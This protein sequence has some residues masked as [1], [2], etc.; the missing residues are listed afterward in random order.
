MKNIEGS[1]VHLDFDN[2]EGSRVINKC[3]DG[4][5]ANL[6]GG[7]LT[8]QGK[9][10]NAIIFDGI[11]DYIH[12]NKGEL[13]SP[14][15][16]SVWVKRIFVDSPSATIVSSNSG[17]IL[18]EQKNSDSKLGIIVDNKSYTFN[19]ATPLGYWTHLI[20]IG[21]QSGVTL[22]V[23]GEY[24]DVIKVD[25]PC[26][27]DYL[28]CN[29]DLT[30]FLRATLDEFMVFNKA[31]NDDEIQ[32]LC[33]PTTTNFK[34]EYPCPVSSDGDP[35][36]LMPIPNKRQLD[37]QKLEYIAFAHFGM[38]T[39]SDREWGDGKE[40]PKDFYPSELSGSQWARVIKN[41]GIKQLILTAKHHDGFCL[42]PSEYTDHCVKNSLW[43][44]GKG[45]VVKEISDA[46]HKENIKFGVYLS[47]WDRHEPTF[48]SGE[49]Y[50]T[51][52]K[53]Q[54]TEL[55]TNYGEISEIWFDGANGS[56][57]KQNYDEE[58]FYSLIHELQPNCIIWGNGWADARWIGNE[59]GIAGET[60]WCKVIPKVTPPYP[61]W[62]M[63]DFNE[64]HAN[65][66]W[67]MPGECDV[68]IRPGWFYHGTEDDKVKTLDELIDL[69]FKSVGRNG[70]LLLNIP[71]DKRGLIHEND[72]KILYAFNNFI[73]NTFSTDFLQSSKV[74]ASST[75]HNDKKYSAN[76]VV[77]CD[78]NT[79]WST[80][81][82]VVTGSLEINLNE[83]KSF[84]IICLQEHIILGQRVT[85]FTVE[86]YEGN[87]W[88]TVA[89]GTT[90]GYKRLIKIPFV[91]T[92]KIRV[93]ILGAQA[94]PV[95]QRIAAYKYKE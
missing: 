88:K 12:I 24:Q 44:D 25:M 16:I 45:D 91:K 30:S 72:E 33:G 76:N 60:N 29:S 35:A 1:I 52:F 22:Y 37:Y 13:N 92:D 78:E 26:P 53:N 23:N 49:P 42:W 9:V 51:Y 43:M 55:L 57:I 69:Y 6:H 19:Y 94:C 79:Y 48:G 58:G 31:L 47:P 73:V 14:W 90:I 71:P 27:L 85:S 83:L 59:E 95:I 68:S 18:L 64:G 80:D 8:E 67:W 54:I 17:S 63:K 46:F 21:T 75:R 84:D 89:S 50:N 20:F 5:F 86:V 77:L 87:Q 62:N 56:E 65:G 11:S 38:N 4:G 81:D 39:F 15:S 32:S 40:N 41:A 28:G 82:G 66:S 93:N 74:I 10:N 36:P 7:T 61:E 2:I 34:S 70:V 3:E